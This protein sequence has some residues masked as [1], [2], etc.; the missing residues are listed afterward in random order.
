MEEEQNSKID[1]N[2]KDKSVTAEQSKDDDKSKEEKNEL[3]SE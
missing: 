1:E 2:I 3:T